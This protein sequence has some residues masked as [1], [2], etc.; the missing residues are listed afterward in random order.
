MARKQID[1]ALVAVGRLRHRAVD[2][3]AHIGAVG[4][5][6]V[7]RDQHRLVGV[8]GVAGDAVRQETVV[9]KRPEHSVERLGALPARGFDHRPP[10]ALEALFEQLRQHAFERLRL[11]VVEQ[12]VG[13]GAS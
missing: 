9:A 1:E 11:E 12:D 6:G 5:G 10:A 8:R 7:H 13:H 3:E 4:V 2:E